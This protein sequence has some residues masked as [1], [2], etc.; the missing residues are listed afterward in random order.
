MKN[1]AD[2]GRVGRES[3]TQ[4]LAL[5]CPFDAGRSFGFEDRGLGLAFITVSKALS[6]RSQASGNSPSASGVV[7]FGLSCGGFGIRSNL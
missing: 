6:N 3:L 4:R 5:V 1:G 2:D 7:G